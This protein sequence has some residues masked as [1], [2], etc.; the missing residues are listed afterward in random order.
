MSVV[1]DLTGTPVI[2]FSLN[3]VAT[4]SLFGLKYNTLVSTQNKEKC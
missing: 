3:C 2:Q 1:Y 4:E